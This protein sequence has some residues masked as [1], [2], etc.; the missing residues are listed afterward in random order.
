[1]LDGFGLILRKIAGYTSP[2]LA[3]ERRV[4]ARFEYATWLEDFHWLRQISNGQWESKNG[5][6]QSLL[7]DGS[8]NPENYSWPSSFNSGVCHFAVSATKGAANDE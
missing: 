6:N 3:C 5:E 4:A 7:L 8:I 1:M 2:I